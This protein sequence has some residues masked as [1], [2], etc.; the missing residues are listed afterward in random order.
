MAVLTT[1]DLGAGAARVLADADGRHGPW[2]PIVTGGASGIGTATG[3]VWGVNG[4][5][6]T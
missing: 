5:R 3:Q 2:G 1:G 4:G 6:N